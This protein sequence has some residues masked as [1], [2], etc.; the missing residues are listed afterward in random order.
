MTDS[1]K[2]VIS[3]FLAATTL[4][5]FSC[6]DSIDETASFTIQISRNSR[7]AISGSFDYQLSIQEEPSRGQDPHGAAIKKLF[8][9]VKEGS[10]NGTIRVNDLP[11]GKTVM[12]SMMIH[13]KGNYRYA[14]SEAPLTLKAGE[15]RAKLIAGK[16]SFEYYQ[17]LLIYLKDLPALES[18]SNYTLSYYFDDNENTKETASIE[19]ID[20]LTSSYLGLPPGSLY[21][22][23]T[24][25]SSGQHKITVD[26]EK[27][28]AT[29]AVPFSS[30]IQTFFTAPLFPGEY[31]KVTVPFTAES[32]QQEIPEPTKENILAPDGKTY[33][34]F[35]DAI[36]ETST[37]LKGNRNPPFPL[38]FKLLNDYKVLQDEKISTELLSYMVDLNGKTLTWNSNDSLLELSSGTTLAVI[39]GKITGS[40]THTSPLIKADA[41]YSTLALK[42]IEITNIKSQDKGEWPD[43]SILYSKKGTVFLNH[44]TIKDCTC[45]HTSEDWKTKWNGAVVGVYDGRFFAI[46]SILENCTSPS[47]S[48]ISCSRSQFAWI[49]GRINLSNADE[50][51]IALVIDN[52]ECNETENNA[53]IYGTTIYKKVHEPQ[54]F[55]AV[56]LNYGGHLNISDGFSNYGHFNFET[57]TPVWEDEETYIMANEILN[58]L[59][60]KPKETTYPTLISAG[61]EPWDGKTQLA[62]SDCTAICITADTKNPNHP[63]EIIPSMLH[64][65]DESK[66]FGNILLDPYTA[67]Q[68]TG[69]LTAKE[70]INIQLQSNS[71]A[72]YIAEEYQ[73]TPGTY[74]LFWDTTVNGYYES[75]E[76]ITSSFNLW[77]ENPEG[78]TNYR[79]EGSWRISRV[80]DGNFFV[81]LPQ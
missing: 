61:L 41:E 66:V 78:S 70:K 53:R 37:W 75:Q 39:N 12:I 31:L 25:A 15:N 19:H 3:A 16:D 5:F 30:N 52:F 44:V 7:S 47:L 59:F 26:I 58:N 81:A 2:K 42:D 50:D 79:R 68:V 8:S 6:T 1:V 21:F 43:T 69:R 23:A 57:F 13:Q 33:S 28:D 60:E 51:M 74:P 67:V 17:T 14:W 64:I 34:T 22:Y 54:Q 46:D 71:Y 48:A 9:L 77:I 56:S 10:S 4:L 35:N 32:G 65:A 72:T 49:G 11:V 38:I 29:G 45:V 40:S 55:P 63:D 62:E 20:E 27:H 80:S 36:S 73:K 24:A 18:D 76:A